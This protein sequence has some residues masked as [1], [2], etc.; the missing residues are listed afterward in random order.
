M[1][2]VRLYSLETPVSAFEIKMYVYGVPLD[3]TT[4]NLK[5]M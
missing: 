2:S 3:M 4:L 1:D 5:C